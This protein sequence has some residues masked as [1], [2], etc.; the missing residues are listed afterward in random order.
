ML[1][2]P[3]RRV[4]LAALLL[5]LL[6]L[7]ITG[8]RAYEVYGGIQQ[9][10]DQTA[11]RITGEPIVTIPPLNSNKRLNFLILGSDNDLKKEEARPLSQSIIVVTVNPQND[12][13]G[14]LS[15]PRDFWVPIQGHGWGKIDLAYKYGGVSLAR[16]TVEHLFGIPIHYYAWVGLSGFIRVIDTLGG[17]SLD[18]AH[19][20]LDDSYP[21][22]LNSQNPYSYKRVFIAPGWQHLNGSTALEYVRSRHG[23]LLSD[24]GRSARQQQVLLA[25]QQKADV[26]NVLR[27]LPALVDELKCCVRTDLNLEQLYQLGT[28][29][30]HVS[31]RDVHQLV[32]QAPF[33]SSYGWA[34]G[35]SIVRPTWRKIRPVVARMFAP[36]PL[37]PTPRGRRAGP[38]PRST[39]TRARPT[40]TPHPRPTPSPLPTA[41]LSSTALYVSGGNLFEVRPNGTVVQ[42][43]STGDVA[44]PSVAG[45]GTIAVFARFERDVSD[46]WTINLKTHVL[47]M[48]T[49]DSNPLRASL[50]DVRNNLWGAW[51]AVSPDGSSILYSSDRAKLSAA[52][53]DGRYDDLAEWIMPASGDPGVQITVPAPGSGGDVSGTWRP[54]SPQFAYVR[55]NYARDNQ[56]FSQLMLYDTTSR[57]LS[58]LTPVGGRVLDPHWDASGKRITFVQGA[59]SDSRIMVADVVPSASGPVLAHLHAVAS[60][61]VTQP[62]FLPGG[63]QVSYLV[64]NHAGFSS[65]VVGTSGGVPVLIPYIPQSIDAVSGLTWLP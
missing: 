4:A 46:I 54:R 49:H 10:T 6:L 30:R 37:P 58:P 52:P 32:L 45:N 14:M 18:V 42:L 23:D 29:A 40:P 41:H 8:W 3:L 16:Q 28:V 12:Q 1:H 43:T 24:F 50:P 57:V 53:S 64:S 63:R 2:T 56:P 48:L 55:W 36:I 9:I 27:N 34:D 31:L 35:Q 20:V 33:Y 44:M 59:G 13:V 65:M 19:P 7:G 60:G 21:N 62:S 15:I 25:L 17:V 39:P 22:D 47:K 38:A 11:P 26:M 51:P 5:L 61:D